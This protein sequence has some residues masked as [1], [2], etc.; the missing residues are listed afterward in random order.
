MTPSSG[1]ASVVPVNPRDHGEWDVGPRTPLAHS[2]VQYFR[3]AVYL[4]YPNRV[5]SCKGGGVSVLRHSAGRTVMNWATT[6]TLADGDALTSL[7]YG[8]AGTCLDAPI[9]WRFS[10]IRVPVVFLYLKGDTGSRHVEGRIRTFHG[11]VN[12]VVH[13]PRA[14][15]RLK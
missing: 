10:A 9:F 13:P 1:T 2:V 15:P 7:S 4:G 8:I 11:H 12:S 6:Q 5:S 3:Q 14:V